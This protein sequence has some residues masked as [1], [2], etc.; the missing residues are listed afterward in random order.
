MGDVPGGSAR[1][2]RAAYFITICHKALGPNYP[3]P[4]EK[5]RHPDY[6][7]GWSIKI[8]SDLPMQISTIIL[9]VYHV[10]YMLL[11]CT[12]K[13]QKNSNLTDIFYTLATAVG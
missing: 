4:N 11:W 13:Q 2:L 7:N 6:K 3:L 1:P 5:F 8:T 9:R 10:L 12:A